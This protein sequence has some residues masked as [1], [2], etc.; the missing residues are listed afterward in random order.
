MSGEVQIELV[1]ET[2][3]PLV[4]RRELVF[5]VSSPAGT[6]KREVLRKLISQ[7]LHVDENLVYM[8]KIIGT[9][10]VNKARVRVNVY[11]SVEEALKFEPKHIIER[12][13]PKEEAK[14]EE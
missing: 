2:Y 7:L 13:K 4:E 1:S 11:K 8:K 12:N 9:Y 3:N 6:P 5:E 14:E 10:G